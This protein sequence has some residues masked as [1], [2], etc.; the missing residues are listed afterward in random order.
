ML[1]CKLK[2]FNISSNLRL[3]GL[4]TGG[5]RRPDPNKYMNE[6]G[7]N[8]KRKLTIDDKYGIFSKTTALPLWS[9]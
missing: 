9:F 3:A 2:H 8:F 4:I 1:A 7:P 5:L 6:Q